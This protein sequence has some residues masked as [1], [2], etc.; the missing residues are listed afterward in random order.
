MHFP[1]STPSRRVSLL[2]VGLAAA[3]CS[4]SLPPEPPALVV[5][6]SIDRDTVLAG[7]SVTL[8]ALMGNGAPADTMIWLQR[9]GDIE[10]G[11]GATAGAVLE[12]P[13][14]YE[15]VIRVAT[16]DGRTAR[17]SVRAVALLVLPA[18][19]LVWSRAIDTS[20]AR[21]GD[22]LALGD[23]GTVY[24]GFQ[25]NDL[26]TF[27]TDGTP[28]WTFE[29]TANLWDHSS[30]LTIAPDGRVFLFDFNGVGFALDAAGTQLWQSQ[31]A[32]QD[33]H[34][35]FALS[36][37]GQLFVGGAFWLRKIDPATGQMVW[38]VERPTGYLSGPTLVADTLLVSQ[39]F[40]TTLFV[41]TSGA[42]VRE[43]TITGPL[44]G[45]RGH[46]QSAADAAGTSYF[47]GFGRLSA[48]RADGSVAWQL[49]MLE[50]TGEPVI[51]SDTTVF[52]A[53]ADHASGTGAAYAVAPDGSVTWQAPLDGYSYIPRLALLDDGTL[54]VALGR[55]L[56]RLSAATG[57][58]VETLEFAEPIGS[59]LAVDGAG[60]VYLM[61]GNQRVMAVQGPAPLDPDAPWPI[62]RRDN[63]RTASVPR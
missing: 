61:T 19:R 34:L 41:D 48:V 15:F 22:L 29:A 20:Q 60:V 7:D 63:R 57:A 16:A 38:E 3:A 10:I 37:D 45:V 27:S 58:V 17:D 53:T 18:D 50:R 39:I 4:D 14:E 55:Y 47:P 36:S 32:G 44:G 9:P 26:L 30:G 8:L 5:T 31:I 13:G 25:S 6:A 62:W 42:V 43:D 1:D 23:D 46:Y 2:A 24:A 28:G 33:A 21:T 54:W 59:A 12:T 56:Y 40:A 35:R 51:G 11:R 49:A 52:V